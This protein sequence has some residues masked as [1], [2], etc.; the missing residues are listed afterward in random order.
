MSQP[1][2]AVELLLL[3]NNIDYTLN[4]V[5]FVNGETR[6]TEYIE[7]VNANGKIPV[8]QD[9][10]FKLLESHAM[11]RY[12]SRKFELKQWYGSEL[13]EKAVIDQWLDWHHLN[14]RTYASD[15][16][17]AI[18]I[19]NFVPMMLKIEVK[20]L[21]IEE[22][23]RKLRMSLSI[24]DKQLENKKFIAGNNTTIVDLSIGCELYQLKCYGYNFSEFKN[25]DKWLNNLEKLPKWTEAHEVVIGAAKEFLSNEKN[26]SVMATVTN[27]AQSKL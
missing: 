20:T 12:L 10:D 13:K 3:I 1:S 27:F 7:T 4:T 5:D 11:M 6:T 17:H 21:Q 8:L 15:M 23:N 16:F 26:A 14:T 2:R 19:V 25:V 22:L 9:D 18:V 24:L